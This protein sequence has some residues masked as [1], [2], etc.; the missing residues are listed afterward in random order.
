[1]NKKGLMGWLVGAISFLIVATVAG[2]FG[3]THISEVSL[4][5]ARGLAIIFGVLF[6]ISVIANEVKDSVIKEA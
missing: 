3:F 5:I 1:M 2:V 6:I 4:T